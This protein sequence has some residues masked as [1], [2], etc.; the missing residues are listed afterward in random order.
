MSNAIEVAHSQ[1]AQLMRQARVQ[2]IPLNVL[3]VDSRY[4]TPAFL[5][6]LHI[7]QNL[8][9]IARLRSNRILFQAPDPS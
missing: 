5:H 6:P 2:A 9:V 4:P 8:V 7:Y 1:V 3:T